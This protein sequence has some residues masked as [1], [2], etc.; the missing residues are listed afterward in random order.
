MSKA[1]TKKSDGFQKAGEIVD[2]QLVG[3]DE[4][5]GR[6]GR[7]KCRAAGERGCAGR[8]CVERRRSRGAGE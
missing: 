2:R 6:G 1:K 7:T 4:I 3:D 8:C 5:G